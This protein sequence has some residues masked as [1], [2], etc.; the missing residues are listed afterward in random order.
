MT[1]RTE[2][3]CK[4]M[5]K[6][7]REAFEQIATGEA[8]PRAMPITL[9]RL[10]TNGLIERG[11]DKVLGRDALG[12]ISIPQYYVPLPVHAQWC[13][14]CSEQLTDGEG[15]HTG[16]LIDEDGTAR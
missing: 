10:Q 1:L 13:Q 8:L 6:R 9:Q 4:G 11:P 14:W 12:V 7:Q 3:P 2:H 5:T 15:A 16:P